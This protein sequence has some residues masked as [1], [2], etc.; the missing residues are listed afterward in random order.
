MSAGTIA[1][2]AVGVAIVLLVS[3]ILAL[4]RG[5]RLPPGTWRTRPDDG[6]DD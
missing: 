3:A 5:R 1:L 6:E 2:I 4:V